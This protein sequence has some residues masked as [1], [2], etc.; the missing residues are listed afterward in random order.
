MNIFT[1][2]L[3]GHLV[4]DWFLQNDWMAQSKSTRILNPAILVHCTIYTMAI[5]AAIGLA[6]RSDASLQEPDLWV[7]A[8]TFLSHWFIDA[9][10]L[11]ERWG[12]LLRQS[13]RA[14]V[15]IMA[16]QT[17]HVVVLVVLAEWLR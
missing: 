3:V 8:V 16:D 9:A 2:L 6:R 15:R 10:H 12:R 13:D 14:F 7:I 4:G 11:A 1:W 5:V 17:L